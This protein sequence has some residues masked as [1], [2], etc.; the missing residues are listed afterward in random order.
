MS[1]DY[2]CYLAKKPLRKI[3]NIVGNNWQI[4]V[5]GP[6]VFERE[7]ISTTL[8]DYIAPR[9]W[10][11]Q[12]HLEGIADDLAYRELEKLLKGLVAKKDACIFDQQEGS[13]LS[14]SGK[15]TITPD[16]VVRE[17][18]KVISL[19]FYFDPIED[20]NR[21]Q[22]ENFF[23]L[24]ETFA[25][26]SL[27]R[28]YG[29]YDPM[30]YSL[31]EHG[32]EHFLDTWEIGKGL[33]W[34]G[35]APFQWVFNHIKNP[36]KLG[37]NPVG[38]RYS[39]IEFLISAKILN[40]KKALSE[41]LIFQT[42]ISKFLD[43]FYSEINH[44]TSSRDSMWRGLPKDPALSVCIGGRYSA[45]WPEFQEGAKNLGNEM[46]MRD[47]LKSDLEKLNPPQMLVRPDLLKDNPLNSRPPLAEVFP[48]KIHKKFKGIPD[49]YKA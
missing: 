19:K 28:R 8:Y 25:P 10:V 14:R 17:E 20:F 13:I 1:L 39:T 42:E 37:P 31:K 35:T 5:N 2:E 22:K 48:F 40:T 47:Y 27:P 4:A 32:K 36:S 41:L 16:E 7:D 9:S 12:I 30:Q 11:L 6:V 21:I 33:Y 26:K 44:E 45:L 24:M 34:R 38:Y 29:W 49:R 18:P 3:R 15:V 43:V 46:F 23:E